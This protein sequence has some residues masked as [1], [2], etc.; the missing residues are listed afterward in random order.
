MSWGDIWKI[1][2]AALASVGGVAGLIVLA[3]KFASNIIADRLSQKY[4]IKLQK[5]L[6]EFKSNLSKKEY[7][8][9][10][11]FDTE[12][13]LYRELSSAFAEMVKAIWVL[14]LAGL[15]NV[16]ADDEDRKE[17]DRKHYEAALPAV[18]NAQD[19]LNANIPF[20][21]E[22]IYDGY[23]ELLSLARVQLSEYEDRFNIYDLR[24]KA[25]K[26][27]FSADAY[28]RTYEMNEKWKALNNTIRDY[29]SK[30]DVVEEK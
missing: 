19:T 8:S 10:T 22:N 30:L 7:V 20:I 23:S 21:S 16:P 25:E 2:L 18:V 9:K 1:I 4:E 13:S 11:K 14:I 6:E 15:T 17:L 24:P 26:E 28:K 3:V 27:R 29:I 12:F 5:D